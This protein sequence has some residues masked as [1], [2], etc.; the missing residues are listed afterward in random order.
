MISML[1]NALETLV[2]ARS[3]VAAIVAAIG[4]DALMDEVIA[5]LDVAF[6]EYGPHDNVPARDGFAIGR[7]RQG[8]LEWMPIMSRDQV[9]IKTVSY[10]PENPQDRNI[11]TILATISLYDPSSG[12]LVALCDGVLATAIRTGAASALASRA[13]ARPN[14]ATLGLIGCGAQ[15]VTQLHALARTFPIK[16]VRIF[17]TDTH[18]AH[19]FVR[20]VAFLGLDVQVAPLAQ[21]EAEADILCTQTSV[22]VGDGPVLR[23]EAL[24]PWV[25]INAVGSDLPGKIEVPRAVLARSL[26]CPDYR[27][28]AVREGECQQL[29]PEQIGPQ[30]FEVLQRPEDYRAHRERPTVFDSTGFAL[31]DRVVAE[32]VLR[33]ARA[34]GRGTLIP[35]EYLAEDPLD[36]YSQPRALSHRAAR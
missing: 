16:Q 28:Q 3:D 12:H 9:L 13:L 10:S 26:V 33:H 21:V 30:L 6:R 22:A 34:L 31:E 8:T 19:S 24:K 4:H 17:D 23:G 35:V 18:V 1:D 36:P 29:A 14:S 11:P 5:G 15:A 25:H 27:L 7:R 2:V 20:R 32:V